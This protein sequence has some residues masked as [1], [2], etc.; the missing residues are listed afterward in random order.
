MENQMLGYVSANVSGN[1]SG[2]HVRVHSNI[3]IIIVSPWL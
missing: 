1:A 3:N 2:Y